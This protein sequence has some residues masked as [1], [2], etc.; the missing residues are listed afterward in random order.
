[1]LSLH[2][3]TPAPRPCHLPGGPSTFPPTTGEVHRPGIA[4]ASAARGLATGE[5]H[6]RCGYLPALLGV[7]AIGAMHQAPWTTLI[8]AGWLT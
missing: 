8:T 6:R 3:G 2:P 1:M 5:V 4:A 7:V